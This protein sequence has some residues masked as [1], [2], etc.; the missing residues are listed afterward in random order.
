[1][2]FVDNLV[3][4]F[5]ASQVAHPRVIACKERIP[6]RKYTERESDGYV[7]TLETDDPT[8][9]T[10]YLIFFASYGVD[11]LFEPKPSLHYVNPE[12][13]KKLEDYAHK[14]GNK[15]FNSYDAICQMKTPLKKGAFTD[16][17]VTPDVLKVLQQHE[18]AKAQEF[19]E[20]CGSGPNCY[21][22]PFLIKAKLDGV[23]ARLPQASLS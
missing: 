8:H 9:P 16:E 11:D 13:L 19:Y 21:R 4:L 15:D 23:Q 1:M 18:I 22:P 5:K 17:V 20:K 7:Y 3:Q 2:F 6:S 12:Y 14:H 10:R